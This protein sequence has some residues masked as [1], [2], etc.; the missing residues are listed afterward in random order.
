MYLVISIWSLIFGIVIVIALIQFGAGWGQCDPS[1][2]DWQETQHLYRYLVF[3]FC[4]VIVIALMYFGT[5][6]GPCDS[7]IFVLVFSVWYLV[8]LFSVLFH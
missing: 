6:W 3:V 7:S 5:G 1:A 8:L 2:S 4:T